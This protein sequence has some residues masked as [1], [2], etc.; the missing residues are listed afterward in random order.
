[1]SDKISVIL[2]SPLPPPNGGIATW[3]VQFIDWFKTKDVDILLINSNTLSNKKPLSS[4]IHKFKKTI[5]I[6]I[7]LI[8]LVKNKNYRIVHIN[9]SLEKFGIYKDYLLIRIARV[10]KKNIIVH[11]RCN[12]QDQISEN[13][14]K[15]KVFISITKMAN[16]NIVLNKKSSEV[17]ENIGLLPLIIPNFISS[18]IKHPTITYNPVIEN[19]LY[20][21]HL[22]KNKGI[23]QIITVAKKNKS[24]LF[25]LVGPN[26]SIR[27][28]EIP[29]NIRLTGEL[30]ISELDY[31][32]S[33]ADLFLFPSH[34]EGFSNAIL[35][36]MSY[37]LPIITTK[38]GANYEI[39]K[40][41]GALYSEIGSVQDIIISI[42]RLKDKSLREKLGLWNYNRVKDYSDSTVLPKFLNIYFN[43]NNTC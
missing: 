36:A 12:I 38:V 22:N 2:I 39:L 30:K 35:E 5:N 11:Y 9:T 25:T 18:N 23:E 34:T 6:I 13:S 14:F 27:T 7:K 16:I 33:V 20:V 4:L 31:F 21:G 26:N 40:N 32:Y 17:L 3:T 28:E 42:S 24:I 41:S 1:M 37:G 19:I 29:S 15:E 8:H 43:L 10:Y